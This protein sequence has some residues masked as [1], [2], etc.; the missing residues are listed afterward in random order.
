M[1]SIRTVSIWRYRPGIAVLNPWPA[2]EQ[3]RQRQCTWKPTTKALWLLPM[4]LGCPCLLGMQPTHVD[5]AQV[6]RAGPAGQPI[7]DRIGGDL[8][9]QCLDP[10][11]R[12]GLAGDHGR[13]PLVTVDQD[14]EQVIRCGLVDADGQESSTMSKSTPLSL[15]SRFWWAIL[16]PRAMTSSRASSSMRV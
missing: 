4:A 2:S 11:G 7:H 10:V 1:V 13:S 14:R 9:R 8:L 16:S 12:T 3:D 6:D 5:I 15:F